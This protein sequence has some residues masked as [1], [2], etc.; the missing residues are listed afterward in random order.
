MALCT[1]SSSL[2]QQL[3]CTMISIIVGLFFINCKGKKIV[4]LLWN[5]KSFLTKRQKSMTAQ[6]MIWISRHFCFELGLRLKNTLSGKIRQSSIWYPGSRQTKS[7]MM[8]QAFFFFIIFSARKTF[9]LSKCLKY[10]KTIWK[11]LAMFQKSIG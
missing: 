10:L 7:L 1:V 4:F 9:S 3:G 5:C 6:K 8:F 11:N 2:L